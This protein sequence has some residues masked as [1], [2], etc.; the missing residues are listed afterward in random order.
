MFIKKVIKKIFSPTKNF[1]TFKVGTSNEESRIQWLKSILAT[2]PAGNKIL[3]AGSGEQQFKKFC[4]HL[5]Y[6]SQDFA[7]YN[8]EDLPFGLQMQQWDY[9]QLDIISDI[10]SIPVPDLSFDVVMCTEVFE[11]IINPREA[12]SEFS[13]V[14]KKEGIL[15][16]TAPFCSLTHF[17]PFHY[18]SGF[19]K[20]FYELELRKN[21]FEIIE[22]TTNGNY[23]EYLAQEINRL[24][25]VGQKYACVALNKVEKE[26]INTLKGTLQ[27]LTDK[28]TGSSELLCFGYH[29]IARKK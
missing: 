24:E 7:G 23:F 13:R 4:S 28:E 15:I 25:S 27:K 1:E 11:H 6:V 17:A 3:D 18:Y 8:P 20:Y 16:L 21:G 9:G 19:N 5:D 2:I 10:A 26:A 22:I 14:L 29:V 12:L